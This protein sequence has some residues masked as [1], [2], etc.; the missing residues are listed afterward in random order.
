MNKNEFEF[1]TPLIRANKGCNNLMGKC[2]A[3]RGSPK[4]SGT[5]DKNI[6]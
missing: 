1:V 2:R 4:Q 3:Q 5:A 6:S